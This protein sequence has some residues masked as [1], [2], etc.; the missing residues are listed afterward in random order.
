MQML[1]GSSKAL[2]AENTAK[3][4]RFLRVDWYWLAT[5]EGEME[6]APSWPIQRIPV[7]RYMHLEPADRGFVK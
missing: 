2:T 6:P 1:T 3:A 7:D 5:G 4:A